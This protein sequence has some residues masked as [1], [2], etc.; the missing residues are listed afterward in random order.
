PDLA[1]GRVLVAVKAASV[2]PVDFKMM[3]GE[4][5][6]PFPLVPGRDL[7]G[8][9]V[10]VGE[11][12]EGFAEGDAVFGSAI[13]GPAGAFAEYAVC[14]PASLAKIPAL[15]SNELAAALPTAVFTAHTA[16]FSV[17]RIGQGTRVLI[18]G[19]S[20][21]VGSLAVQLA[22]RAGAYVVGSASSANRAY[23][24]ALELDE[25]LAY[26]EDPKYDSVHDIDVAFDFVGGETTALAGHTLG[27]GGRLISIAN[28][29]LPALPNGTKVEAIQ[30]APNTRALREAGELV[31]SGDLKV[32]IEAVYELDDIRTALERSASHRVRG[33]LVVTI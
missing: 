15:L 20:G 31:V 29:E 21:G 32:E 3:A 28:F 12:V 7:A 11:G 24:T 9:V 4:M 33:K 25:F 2:N 19:A 18:A 5:G 13:W 6:T 27:K 14:D 22:T 30:A 17:G 23:I 1:P 26:D 16:L 10:E 8:I